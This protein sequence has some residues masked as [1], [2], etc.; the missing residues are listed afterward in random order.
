MK[1][2]HICVM[3]TE[4]K[5]SISDI[6][7]AKNF[8]LIDKQI[9]KS[10]FNLDDENFAKTIVEQFIEKS[11]RTITEM[12]ASVKRKKTSETYQLAHDLCGSC[13]YIGTERMAVISS[14]IY[15][16]AKKR[17]IPPLKGSIDQ[18]RECFE[19]SKKVRF[20]PNRS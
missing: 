14:F 5:Y 20:S 2:L 4:E 7:E 19:E 1:A 11:E 18:L 9:T 10:V 16:N 12:D 6:S 15:Y 17:N 13:L 3:V 8:D